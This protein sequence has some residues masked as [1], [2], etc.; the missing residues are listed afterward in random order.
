MRDLGRVAKVRRQRAEVKRQKDLRVVSRSTAPRVF[1][2]RIVSFD[3]ADFFLLHFAF[4]L[5]ASRRKRRAAL[6]F[7][8]YRG[9]KFASSLAAAH[10]HE[11]VGSDYFNCRR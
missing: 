4:L 2:M 5:R 8:L 1:A 11:G 9:H 6:T 3:A 7:G 10:E